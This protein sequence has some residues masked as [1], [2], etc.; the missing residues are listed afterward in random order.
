MLI[1]FEDV[2]GTVYFNSDTI[3]S[4]MIIGTGNDS[5]VRVKGNQTFDSVK[6]S[7]GAA[8]GIVDAIQ[9]AINGP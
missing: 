9:T 7:S 3:T 6:L 1:Q 5:V 4:I 2:G 8:Q